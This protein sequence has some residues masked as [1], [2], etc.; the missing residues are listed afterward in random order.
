VGVDCFIGV[1]LTM[2]CIKNEKFL[3]SLRECQLV[4]NEHIYTFRLS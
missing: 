1:L 2:V 3:H 4:S